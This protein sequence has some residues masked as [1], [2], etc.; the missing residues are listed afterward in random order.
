MV[1]TNAYSKYI[2][3]IYAC[4]TDPLVGRGKKMK[5]LF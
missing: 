1:Q 4:T 2:P 3:A 5:K